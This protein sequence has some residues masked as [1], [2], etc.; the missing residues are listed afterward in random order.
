[1]ILAITIIVAVI[2]IAVN[3]FLY[4]AVVVSTY[5][6]EV[7]ESWILN[8]KKNVKETYDALKFVDEREIFERDDEVG[9][10]FSN[11]VEIISD[12]NEKTYVEQEKELEENKVRENVSK[13]KRVAATFGRDNR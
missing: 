9:F 2:S 11:I 7:Y 1:M 3:I 5:R 12:L 13:N 6:V 4:R 8:F 10:V